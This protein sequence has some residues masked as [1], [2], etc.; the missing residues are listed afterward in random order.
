VAAQAGGYHAGSLKFLGRKR[1]NK[2]LVNEA[3]VWCRRA[4]EYPRTLI[5]KLDFC[6]A[7]VIT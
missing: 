1:L 2:K 6:A 5:G 4:A 7:A 3:Q